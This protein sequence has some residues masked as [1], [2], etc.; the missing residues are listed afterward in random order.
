MEKCSTSSSL[1]LPLSHETMKKSYK[2]LWWPNISRTDPMILINYTE[3]FSHVKAHT[4]ERRRRKISPKA[5]HVQEPRK[6][7][8]SFSFFSFASFSYHYS[9]IFL[10]GIPWKG[11]FM[12]WSLS[13]ALP[14]PDFVSHCCKI[15][16]RKMLLWGY[17]MWRYDFTQSR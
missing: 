4:K 15:I 2:Y 11:T 12:N 14:W 7:F 17:S 1:S 13:L 16:D 3:N 9:I 10:W 5:M 8:F 6:S